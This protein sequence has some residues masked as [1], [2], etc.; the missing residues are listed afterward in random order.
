[1]TIRGK[2]QNRRDYPRIPLRFIRATLHPLIK[3][4]NRL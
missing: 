4:L 1:M 2:H 3:T